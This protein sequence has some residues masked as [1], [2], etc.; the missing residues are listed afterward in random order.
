MNVRL[1]KRTK[2]DT[3]LFEIALCG[4][5]VKGTHS[6]L[7]VSS[8]LH[9]LLQENNVWCTKFNTQYNPDHYH[10][11]WTAEENC[12]LQEKG[13]VFELAITPSNNQNVDFV[14]YK[15]CYRR[16][17]LMELSDEYLDSSRG[18]NA[19]QM[20]EIDLRQKLERYAV[21]ANRDFDGFQFLCSVAKPEQK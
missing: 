12:K 17:R 9:N 3:L 1:Y 10:A 5:D 19:P 16:S 8:S 7:Q 11:W 13:G 6:L 2:M 20:V 18:Y 15:P 4:A 21:F 14:L